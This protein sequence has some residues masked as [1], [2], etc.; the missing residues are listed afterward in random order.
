MKHPL[1]LLVLTTFF[2]FFFVPCSSNDTVFETSVEVPSAT[3]LRFEPLQFTV[4]VPNAEDCYEL[5]LALDID[6]LRYRESALP[7]TLS[8][9]SPEGETRTLY[10]TM[11]LRSKE[12][13]SL[14]Q[15]DKDGHLVFPQRIREY[16][17]F[18]QKGTHT[19][20]VGQRTSRFEIKGIHRID[21]SIRKA[22]LELPK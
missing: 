1:P 12:G 14:G 8:V 3:W 18:N 16:F 2:L 15:P 5:H 17:Y 20:T 19:V 13:H 21:F 7:L 11:M 10:T 6:T 4:D 9:V 22:K